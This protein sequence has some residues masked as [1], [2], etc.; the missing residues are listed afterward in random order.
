MKTTNYISEEAKKLVTSL[1]RNLQSAK[2]TAKDKYSWLL[3]VDVDDLID[4]PFIDQYI[5]ELEE[6]V[7]DTE[8]MMLSF[9][10]A[11]SIFDQLTI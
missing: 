9:D 10:D 2:Q 1:E 4:T 11:P 7:L 6:A 8:S 3:Q 5:Y